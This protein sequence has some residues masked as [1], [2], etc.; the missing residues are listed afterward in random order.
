[1]FLSVKAK[2]LNHCTHYKHV[3]SLYVLL[4][5]VSAKKEQDVNQCRKDVHCHFTRN[6][7]KFDIL[8]ARLKIVQSSPETVKLKFFNYLPEKARNQSPND[9]QTSVRMLPL[10]HLLY[11]I[12]EF[13]EIPMQVV[14]SFLLAWCAAFYIYF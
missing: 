9:F 8:Y 2:P 5:L 6:R 7:N 4:L 11:L 10:A 12:S 1:M 3:F 13:F 14:S